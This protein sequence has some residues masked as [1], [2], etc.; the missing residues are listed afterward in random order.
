MEHTKIESGFLEDNPSAEDFIRD[1]LSFIRSRL[2]VIGTSVYLLEESLKQ[3]RYESQK[4][5]RKIYNEIET[6]R[7]VINQ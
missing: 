3:D 6:I 2:N 5:I 1:F 7:S 4:Y